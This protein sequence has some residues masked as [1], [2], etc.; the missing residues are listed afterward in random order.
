MDERDIYYRVV[1][2]WVHYKSL[3]PE[4]NPSAFIINELTGQSFTGQEPKTAVEVMEIVGKI[5]GLPPLSEDERNRIAVEASMKIPGFSPNNGGFNPLTGV[6]I[7]SALKWIGYGLGLF[8]IFYAGFSWWVI[9][10]I[11]AFWWAGGAARMAKQKQRIE[12]GPSWEMPAH[13]IIHLATFIGLIIVS[14][15]HIL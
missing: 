11:I 2:L 5:Q 8:S 3:Y 1:E 12:P 7:M 10:F 15:K 9:G 13:I 4:S 14:I 6:A